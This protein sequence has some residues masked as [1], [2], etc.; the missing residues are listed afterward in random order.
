MH[1]GFNNVLI[2]PKVSGAVRREL[3][4]LPTLVRLLQ[5]KKHE[6]R[7]FL[8]KDIAPQMLNRLLEDGLPEE[9]IVR[10][11]IPVLP[12]Y[13]RICRGKTYWKKAVRK[14]NLDLISWPYYPLPKLNLPSILTVHDMRFLHYPETYKKSRRM[15]LRFAVPR[16]LERANQIISVS[17][18]TKRDIV[19][20]YNITPEKI[21][22]VPNVID[23][24][25]NKEYSQQE[26]NDIK[27]RYGLPDRYILYVGTLEPR[28]N[29]TR[30]VKAF[31]N[32]RNR[33]KINE[34]LVILG[35]K[36]FGYQDLCTYVRRKNIETDVL[37]TG[38]VADEHLPALYQQARMLSFPSQHEGFGIPILE[39]MVCKT[40]VLTSNTSAMPEV[41]GEAAVLVNPFSV[42]DIADGIETICNN[43][44]LRNDLIDKGCKR[45]KHFSKDKAVAK[46]AACYEL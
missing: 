27:H 9:C 20:N 5:Q 11:P 7:V 23:P 43:E 6:C 13:K 21:K 25:F 32:L 16:S 34:K 15:F 35:Q 41:A 30:L 38:Y 45:I 28:K 8:A 2:I 39:A 24:R 14:N 18:C 36:H 3:D 31:A 1:I 37:F 10:T 26:I 33:N 4:L 12:T 19:K 44:E 42:N 22:V 46:L 40:P 29:L 17:E